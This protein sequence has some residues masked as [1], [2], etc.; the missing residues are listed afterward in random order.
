MEA[1]VIFLVVNQL[2][3]RYKLLRLYIIISSSLAITTVLEFLYLAWPSCFS[4]NTGTGMV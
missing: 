2:G 1:L 4:D 3:E